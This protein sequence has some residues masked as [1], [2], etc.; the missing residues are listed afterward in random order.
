MGQVIQKTGG[1]TDPKI[2]QAKMEKAL[3][4]GL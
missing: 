1:K 4:S 2:L 3:L